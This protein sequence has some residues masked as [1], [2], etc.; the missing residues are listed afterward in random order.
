L[1]LTLY[2][3]EPSEFR[4][5]ESVTADGL[6]DEL[7]GIGELARETGL[8][9]SALR[10]YDRAGLLVPAEVDPDTG[11]RRYAGRQVA[12]ARLVA[13]LRRVGMPLVEIAQVLAVLPDTM[14]A[15]RLIDAHLRHLEDGLADARREL[16]RVHQLLD[17]REGNMTDP[18]T[19]VSVAAAEMAAAL[20]AVR[21]AVSTDP[22]LPV[23]GGVLVAAEPGRLEV[24]ATDRFRLAA[25]QVAAT[26]DGPPVRVVVP[27]AF[28]DEV[29]GRLDAD[30]DPVMLTMTGSV[31]AVEIAGCRV[32]GVAVSGE[33]PDHQRLLDGSADAATR[34]LVPVDVLA[35][36]ATLTRDVTSLAVREHAGIASPVAVLSVHPDGE[37][38]VV[39]PSAWDSDDPYQVA[40]NPEFLLQAL[41]AGGDGQLV[42]DLDGPI[43]PLAIRTP[44][45]TRRFS[46][47]MPVR[48]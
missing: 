37:L 25:A 12:P 41:D 24:V 14:A 9:V 23:L 22:E 4:G 26:V 21:F 36:R 29:R 28:I 35:L 20:D 18:M 11:Y 39:E 3:V 2:L 6:R 5:V 8:T 10:F 44:G 17:S 15:R 38:R 32:T 16:S 30:A 42:L 31:L 40:V 48:L 43:R 46:V 13:G 27:A 47:L 7:R 19:R 1:C 45:N 33:F 34:H